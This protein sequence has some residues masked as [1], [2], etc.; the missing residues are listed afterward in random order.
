MDSEQ[1]LGAMVTDEPRI[2]FKDGTAGAERFADVNDQLILIGGAITT[3]KRFAK[4]QDSLCHLFDNGEICCYGAVI[5]TREDL[6]FLD[7][8]SAEGSGTP[9]ENAQAK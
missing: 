4:W 8:D 7:A 1:L 3:Q 6:L 2:K 5:G 9:P